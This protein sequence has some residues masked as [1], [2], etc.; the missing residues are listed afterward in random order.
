[1]T[2]THLHPRCTCDHHPGDPCNASCPVHLGAGLRFN[3]DQTPRPAIG[4]TRACPE[5][6]CG[7]PQHY[8][9]TEL[10]WC[11]DAAFATLACGASPALLAE[12]EK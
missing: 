5:P 10:G 2:I 6:G 4:S 8:I 7:R 11:H 9:G 1:M 3:G 12:L